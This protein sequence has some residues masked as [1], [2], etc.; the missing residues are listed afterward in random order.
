MMPVLKS[1]PIQ[2]LSAR[3]GTW[4]G[5]HFISYQLTHNGPKKLIEF[6]SVEMIYMFTVS[7]Y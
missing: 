2:L 5:H 4:R 6:S 1:Q 3:R 7:I